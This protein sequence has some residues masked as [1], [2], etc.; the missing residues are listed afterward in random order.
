MHRY[1]TL[2]DKIVMLICYSVVIAMIIMMV[3]PFW[4]QF[5]MSLSTRQ[6]ALI[7]GFRLWTWPLNLDGYKVVLR[8]KELGQAAL[9]TLFRVVVG[10]GWTVVITA[11]TA[12]P[13]SRKELPFK[14]PLTWIF[15]FTM[16]FSG[17]MIPTYIWIRGL[18]LINNRLVLILPGIA[19]Y[20]LII[21]RNF[22]SG[23]PQ[24][25]QEAA[26]M[27]GADDIQLW[28]KIVLPLSKP[29]L[30]T[31]ALWTAVNHWN[32]YFDALIYMTDK[33]KYVLQILLR[34]AL[35]DADLIQFGMQPG[36]E[37]GGILLRPTEDTVKAALLMVTTIPIL[38]VYPFAQKYFIKGILQGSIKG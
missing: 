33:S 24:E 17:G 30:A 8:S 13:L 23:M 38:L 12:Y 32:A 35:L 4:D 15:V 19:A 3:Y 26:Q 1:D 11:L 18:G 9:N 21:M 5:V 10:T 14:G 31:I 20:Y 36:Q 7:G 6:N 28:W 25:I 16:F 29:I 2:S 22:F 27:D 37:M 34:R